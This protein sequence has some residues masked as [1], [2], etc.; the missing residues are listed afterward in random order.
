MRA[1]IGFSGAGQIV[2]C[3]GTNSGHPAKYPENIASAVCR[4]HWK[5]PQNWC[6]ED[7]VG[8]LI[9]VPG[10]TGFL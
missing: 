7:R 8:D 6:T 4:G 9:V 3:Y 5:G 2:G 10:G 1:M